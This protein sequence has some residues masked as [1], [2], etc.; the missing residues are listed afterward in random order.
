MTGN[1][2]KLNT[3]DCKVYGN[4]LID[5]GARTGNLKFNSAGGIVHN[6]ID[7][8]AIF[9]LAMTVDFFFDDNSIKKMADDINENINLESTDYSRETFV[10]ALKEIVGVE[11]ADELISQMSLNG[12]IKR[13]PDEINK[14]LFLNDVKLKWYEDINSYKSFGKIGIANINKEEVNKYVDGKI[15]ITKK[16]SGDLIDILLEADNGTWYYFSY[17]RGLM[18]VISSNETFNTQI[19][20]LKKDKR[21]YSNAKGEKP[22]SYMFGNEKEKRDFIR[23]FE[24]EL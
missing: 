11:K 17:R 23:D 20:E 6:Q 1:Y 16:R 12:K 21:K 5:I 8:S 9:D 22:F 14:R 13:M 18:K 19:K 2:L 10:S 7:N 3:K 4:G 15:M 24:S